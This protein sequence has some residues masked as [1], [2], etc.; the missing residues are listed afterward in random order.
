MLYATDM[1]KKNSTNQPLSLRLDDDLLAEVDAACTETKL[2][3][4]DV[5]RLSIERG[6]KVLLAQ[7][8]TTPAQP[9]EGTAAA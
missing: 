3:R 4:S 1:A 5:A 6:L 2:S 9:A 8:K 7:L